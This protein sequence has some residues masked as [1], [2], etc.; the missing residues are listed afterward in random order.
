MFDRMH[1]HHTICY[2]IL[3]QPIN[4]MPTFTLAP[5]Y[6]TYMALWMSF[7][8]LALIMMML[9]RRRLIPEWQDYLRLL[10]MPWKLA[11]FVPALLFVSFAGRFTNDE[12]WDVVT[13]AGMSLLTFLTA[14]WS[15][16][17]IYQ[18]LGGTRPRRYLIVALAL[19]LFSSSWFYDAWQLWRDGA[20]SG[21]WWSNLMFSPIIYL[22][23]GLLWNLEAREQRDFL[24]G[25]S[26][27]F[28]FMRADWPKRPAD[29][30]FAPL[31]AASAPLIVAAALLLT[32][33]V[34][35]KLP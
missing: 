7:C 21:R 25:R 2:G 29:G 26:V 15:V 32:G 5:F 34:R 1:H 3:K 23:G 20:Y 16:G 18:V 24:D 35:W 27:Q 11:L 13:G 12:T 30:R 22:A 9:D 6:L 33:L 10:F 14:P 19:V 28:S 8:L 17:L 31:A 4:M